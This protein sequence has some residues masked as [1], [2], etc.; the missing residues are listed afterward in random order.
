MRTFLKVEKFGGKVEKFISLK[1]W[2][3][4]LTSSSVPA[5]CAQPLTWIRAEHPGCS[6]RKHWGCSHLASQLPLWLEHARDKFSWQIALCR[7]LH[8]FLSSPSIPV[9]PPPLSRICTHGS[10]PGG[11]KWPV[12]EKKRI[13]CVS[14]KAGPAQPAAPRGHY[15]LY[16]TC[17]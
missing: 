3:W 1:S 14:P 12:P 13:L 5:Q 7:L 11:G 6:Q 2:P 15:I 4:R 8:Q 10:H 9:H 16:T 17:V